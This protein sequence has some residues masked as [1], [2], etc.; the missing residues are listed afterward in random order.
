MQVALKGF[1]PRSTISS[2]LP[3]LSLIDKFM[4]MEEAKGSKEEAEEDT[5]D[6]CSADYGP[7]IMKSTDLDFIFPTVEMMLRNDHLQPLVFE[8]VPYDAYSKDQ[9][10]LAPSILDRNTEEVFDNNENAEDLQA[11]SK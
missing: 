10:A 6:M 7:W 11:T 5:Q 1:R 2:V 8:Q 4:D 9:K 3:R